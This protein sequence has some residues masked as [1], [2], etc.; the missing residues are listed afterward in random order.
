MQPP[1]SPSRRASLLSGKPEVRLLSKEPSRFVSCLAPCPLWKTWAWPPHKDP[2]V[3]VIFS[4][5]SKKNREKKMYFFIGNRVT[6]WHISLLWNLSYCHKDLEETGR[7]GQGGLKRKH[8][9]Y[10]FAF[11]WKQP[12]AD[13]ALVLCGQR[14]MR[15]G[16]WQLVRGCC[17][18]GLQGTG[19]HKGT[20]SQGLQTFKRQ[21]PGTHVFLPSCVQLDLVTVSSQVHLEIGPHSLS[22]PSFLK[23]VSGHR[24]GGHHGG[25]IMDNHRTRG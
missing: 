1:P 4:V 13:M 22:P 6:A 23:T 21:E 10:V 3:Y 7:K 11:L 14:N 5:L 20:G 18:G 2:E 25:K 24:G 9:R 19:W 15:S 17:S 8:S 16:A 12:W